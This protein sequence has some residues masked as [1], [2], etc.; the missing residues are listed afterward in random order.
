LADIQAIGK[1]HRNP[2][3]HELEEKYT[4]AEAERLFVLT[5]G[6]LVHLAENGI[7]DKP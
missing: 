7:K 3:I 2:A 6:F 4:E 5:E 1:A